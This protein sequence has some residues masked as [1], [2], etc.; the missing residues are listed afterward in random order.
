VRRN[1]YEHYARNF[2][3]ADIG[4]DPAGRQQVG[5][6]RT[7]E[8]SDIYDRFWVVGGLS[9]LKILGNKEDSSIGAIPMLASAPL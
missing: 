4:F 3:E 9:A 6:M 8:M 5:G 2:P 1:K 7:S